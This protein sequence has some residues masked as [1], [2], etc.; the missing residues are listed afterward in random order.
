M[1]RR[2]AN[3]VFSERN[4]SYLILAIVCLCGFV[5]C[6]KKDDSYF[7][8][9]SGYEWHYQVQATTMD[10]VVDQRLILHSVDKRVLDDQSYS[11]LRSLTGLLY[12]YRWTEEGLQQE[13]YLKA[14]GQKE[15]F[16]SDR[17]LLLPK[18]LESGNEWESVMKTRTLEH[19]WNSG[20]ATV[21]QMKAKVP[22]T[23][24][25]EKTDAVVI[26]AAG[27][28]SNCVKISSNGFAFHSGDRYSERT[29]VEI[30]QSNWYAP[31]VGLVKSVLNETSSSQAFARGGWHMEL[32]SY[33]P[34]KSI[35]NL[36]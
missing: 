26:T 34:P 1:I 17:I 32:A 22:V 2:K 35:F 21:S 8:L 15:E 14:N 18:Q 4:G 6:S 16:I 11:V 28:F 20:E 7:P 27:R 10:G 30:K 25:I 33:S 36:H 9:T 23:N 31:G 13:G 12:L 24:T 5:A 19:K 29:V 3:L